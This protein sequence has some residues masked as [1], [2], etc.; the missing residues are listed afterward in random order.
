MKAMVRTPFGG[1]SAIEE[2]ELLIKS[3]Q[4]PEVLIKVYAPSVNSTWRWFS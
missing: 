4:A 3:L 1:P 2:R